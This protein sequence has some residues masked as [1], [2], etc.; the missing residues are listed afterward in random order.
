M[1]HNVHERRLPVPAERVGPLLDRLGGP[2]DELWPAPA[3]SPMVLDGPVAPGASGGHGGI[4]Y[5][6]TEHQP[7]R[8]VTFTFEPGQG[9]HGTHTV[10]VRPA[11]PSATVLRH[12]SVGRMTGVMRLLWPLAVRWAHDALLEDSLDR[13]EATLGTGPVRPARWSPWVRLLQ[14][15]EVPR[16][17]EV[18]VPDTPLLADALPRVDWSDAHAVGVFRGAPT[19]PQVWADA[20]FRD[21]PRW[22]VAVLAL[23]EAGVRLLGIPPG[24]P[25]SFV[26]RARAADEV[27]LG[28]DEHHLD[29]RVAV[30]REPQ[31]VVVSTVVALH[32]RRG[33]A[34]FALVRHIHPVVLQAMLNRAARKLSRSSNPVQRQ[35]ATL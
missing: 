19:D 9:L 4:R 34:Y 11:G 13:A 6:V 14:R 10:S 28:A 17:R 25:S 2:D 20:V 32:N 33:R 16:A 24:T 22:V 27:L 15:L 29:F 21:P 31:R 8:S 30:L 1:V 12:E 5:R 26:T 18:E 35:P 7:G 3:W 23:R